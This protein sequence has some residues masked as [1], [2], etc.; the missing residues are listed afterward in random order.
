MNIT[1]FRRQ[2]P[3]YG[4][5]SDSDVAGRLYAQ[6][7]SNMDE[8]DFLHRFIGPE[9]IPPAESDLPSLADL[10]STQVPVGRTATLEDFDTFMPPAR[11]AME[12]LNQRLPDSVI[13]DTPENIEA[14]ARFNFA[15]DNGFDPSGVM[16]WAAGSYR[17]TAGTA[18]AATSG[19]YRGAAD[20]IRSIANWNEASAAGFG[21]KGEGFVSEKM[22][23]AAKWLDDAG[24]RASVSAR[25][26][27]LIA[28]ESTPENALLGVLSDGL[29]AIPDMALVIATTALTRNP[30]AGYAVMGAQV[31][32]QTY[33]RARYQEGKG[34]ATALNDAFFATAAELGPERA[35]RVLEP[36]AD[37]SMPVMKTLW[38][39]GKAEFMAEGTTEVLT[40]L[41]EDFRQGLTPGTTPEMRLRTLKA[42]G[43]GVVAGVGM[44]GAGSVI[45]GTANQLEQRTLT[46]DRSAFTGLMNTYNE[47][48]SGGKLPA[49]DAAFNQATR[50][51]D[52]GVDKIIQGE[53]IEID[54]LGAE[55]DRQF[56]EQGE[57]VQAPEET[58]PE[59][60]VENFSD[61][62]ER[63]Y[64]DDGFSRSDLD[65]ALRA[66]VLPGGGLNKYT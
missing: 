50:D 29:R 44:G 61:E 24:S 30:N 19:L 64:T 32:A 9:Q 47:S 3:Q 34:V 15:K 37:A 22:R 26:N 48:P 4:S 10:P 36:I 43:T 31:A 33:G 46:R 18:D 27:Q 17:H 1:D 56:V 38:K 20:T 35:F 8:N 45:T 11:S 28:G 7:F 58:I 66:V 55:L 39:T 52:A 16:D 62:F 23:S 42:A 12:L 5:L 40:L 54:R 49:F 14:M 53:G 65:T 2:Y 63:R 13:P 57:L 59:Q 6:Y 60:P 21:M 41:D 25:Y 51:V